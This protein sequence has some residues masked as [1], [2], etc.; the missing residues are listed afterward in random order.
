[1]ID[2]SARAILLIREI[3]ER[4]GVARLDLTGSAARDDFDPVSSDVDLLVEFLPHANV[5][6]IAFVELSDALEQVFGRRV[7]LIELDAVRNPILRDAFARDRMPFY[8][9]A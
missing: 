1:M 9:A 7:D 4:H 5:S 8:A 3:C 2:V 6:A